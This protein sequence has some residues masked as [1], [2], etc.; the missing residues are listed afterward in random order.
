[1]ADGEPRTEFR[2]HSPRLKKQ[3]DGKMRPPI[4]LRLQ[5]ALLVRTA[6]HLNA[7]DCLLAADVIVTNAN[8]AAG[9]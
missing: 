4:F 5:A 7:G 1:M 9:L 3:A 8:V 6:F 2:Q